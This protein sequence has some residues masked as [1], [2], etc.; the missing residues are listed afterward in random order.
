MCEDGCHGMASSACDGYGTSGA[1]HVACTAEC[2]RSTFLA[3]GH[4]LA[5]HIVDCLNTTYRGFTMRCTALGQLQ[6]LPRSTISIA[7]KN[8][9]DTPSIDSASKCINSACKC[10]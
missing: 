6:Q 2:M 5:P 1:W 7:L 3:V 8:Y 4:D 10:R 9:L